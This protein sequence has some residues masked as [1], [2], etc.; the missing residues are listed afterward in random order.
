MCRKLE[1]RVLLVITTTGS[2]AG[3]VL[4]QANVR[5]GFKKIRISLQFCKCFEAEVSW[6]SLNRNCE[7]HS[8]ATTEFPFW[9]VTKFDIQTKRNIP[10]VTPLHIKQKQKRTSRLQIQNN[11]HVSFFWSIKA[12]IIKKD[13]MMCINHAHTAAKKLQHIRMS[14]T[15]K[16]TPNTR[17]GWKT[18]HPRPLKQRAHTRFDKLSSWQLYIFKCTVVSFPP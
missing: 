8:L 5:A 13:Y 17:R 10:S 2:E 14:Q 16:K 7:C 18:P 9:P 4:H 11:M 12:N 6:Q 1:L 3:H 15:I